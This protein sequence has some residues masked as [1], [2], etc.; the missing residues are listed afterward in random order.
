VA[1][2]RGLTVD[3]VV[4]AAAEIADTEGLEHVTLAAVAGR[5]KVRSPSLYSHV[6]GLDGVR[7]MLALFSAGELEHALAAAAEGRHGIEALRALAHEYRN[8]A[9]H[10]PGLYAAAQRAVAP[11]EDDELYRA[12]AAVLTPVL[13]AFTEAG[14]QAEALI[15]LTRGFRS[16]LHGFVDLERVG[17]FGMPDSVDQSFEQLLEL[18]LS[19][20]S[21][22]A[23]GDA[24]GGA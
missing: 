16:A 5:L 18:L 24:G 12:L 13:R 17:G 10:H 11:G 4:A 9:L 3:D 2:K 14:V 20:V 6:A 21:A 15:H 7:R 8:F 23:V 1:R 19:G 22:V